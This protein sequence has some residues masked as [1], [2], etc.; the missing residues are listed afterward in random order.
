MHTPKTAIGKDIAFV[1]AYGASVFDFLSL[2]F[3]FE[4][5]ISN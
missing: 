5:N 1:D 4:F 2:S 3:A